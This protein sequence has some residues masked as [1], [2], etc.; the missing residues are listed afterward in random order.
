[1]Q[2]KTVEEKKDKKQFLSFREKKYKSEAKYIDNNYFMI[3]EIFAEKLHFTQNLKITPVM[4]LD[5]TG[6]K[7]VNF[8]LEF[9]DKR[10]GKK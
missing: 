2:L 9:S 4:I 8:K 5:D 7:Y 1:M 10:G 6:D 3:E